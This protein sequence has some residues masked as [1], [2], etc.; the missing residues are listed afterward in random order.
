MSQRLPRSQQIVPR[1]N[2]PSLVRGR[3]IEASRFQPS[4]T[5]MLHALE[6]KQPRIPTQRELKT[7]HFVEP[8]N[9][10]RHIDCSAARNAQRWQL[11]PSDPLRTCI[12]AINLFW[13][14][15]RRPRR[16]A[17]ASAAKISRSDGGAA[18][19][20]TATALLLSRF[21]ATIAASASP[22]RETDAPSKAFPTAPVPANFGPCCE[23]CTGAGGKESSL[24]QTRTIRG[25]RKRIFTGNPP[26]DGN[27]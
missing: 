20:H 13:G 27:N 23:N 14:Q 16:A 9:L 4:Q 8:G 5:V 1:T 25:T 7:G 11:K 21:A 22:E 12:E 19:T 24:A 26:G 17:E 15:A 6:P 18:K 2:K 10:Q 3:E